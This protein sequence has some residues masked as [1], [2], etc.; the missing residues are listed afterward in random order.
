MSK[1]Q[2]ITSPE[3]ASVDS[4][5]YSFVDLANIL[6]LTANSLNDWINDNFQ[7]IESHRIQELNN[8]TQDLFIKSKVLF[9]M[10]AVQIAQNNASALNSLSAAS[11]KIATTI[12]KIQKVQ[13]VIDLTAKLVAMGGAV[14][15]LDFGNIVV[16]VSDILAQLT[17]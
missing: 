5:D 1:T 2:L 12:K 7:N 8:K 17:T 9:Q 4:E 15:D 6:Q 16:T 3:L 10:S 11:D 14:A 13:E